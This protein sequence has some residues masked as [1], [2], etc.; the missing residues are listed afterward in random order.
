MVKGG[1]ES[2]LSSFLLGFVG[3]WASRQIGKRQVGKGQG[4]ALTYQI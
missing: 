4:N 1:D 3:K 2:L